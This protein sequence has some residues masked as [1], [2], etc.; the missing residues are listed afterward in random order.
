[1]LDFATVDS[2]K[3]VSVSSR[4]MVVSRS[5]ILP[6][7]ARFSRYLRPKTTARGVIKRREKRLT[8]AEEL[9]LPPDVN[10]IRKIKTATI[11]VWKG[12]KRRAKAKRRKSRRKKRGDATPP[13][14]KIS[15]SATVTKMMEERKELIFWRERRREAR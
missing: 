4:L 1:M 2:Q 11:A 9:R 10:S 7:E 3:R 14:E 15:I 13:V 12:S 5:S 6:R 8:K